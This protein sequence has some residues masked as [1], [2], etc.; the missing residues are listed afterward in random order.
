MFVGMHHDLGYISI[1]SY[2]KPRDIVTQTREILHSLIHSFP[3]RHTYQVNIYVHRTAFTVVLNWRIQF[4]TGSFKDVFFW[5]CKF[6]TQYLEYETSKNKLGQ[7]RSS[8]LLSC[9]C[10]LVMSALWWT[11]ED[12]KHG[13][14][15][16]FFYSNAE[17]PAFICKTLI[18][19]Q[20]ENCLSLFG[21]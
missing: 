7:L 12:V 14:R 15:C 6:I 18:I 20:F 9:E 3:G 8:N 1:P 4:R 17:Q 10:C 2:S 5:N 11:N 13:G 19:V 21:L 16:F